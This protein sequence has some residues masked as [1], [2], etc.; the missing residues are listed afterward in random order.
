[1]D[2][3]ERKRAIERE[4]AEAGRQRMAE[5]RVFRDIYHPF[6]R[7]SDVPFIE[8]ISGRMLEVY[9]AVRDFRQHFLLV[10]IA[11][12]FALAEFEVD[13]RI[14]FLF[15]NPWH[16]YGFL[17]IDNHIGCARIPFIS[18]TVIR[19]K[20]RKQVQSN[21]TCPICLTKIERSNGK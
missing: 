11:I 20:S 18:Y 4:Q 21:S 8:V 12:R 5:L 17:S 16:I 1:M 6:M 10:I 3:Y 13:P 2:R 14:C 7:P 15:F 9:N 19:G